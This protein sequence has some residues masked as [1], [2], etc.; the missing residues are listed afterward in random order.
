MRVQFILIMIFSAL[1]FGWP[2]A[3]AN[4]AGPW[5]AQIVDADTGKSLDGVVVLAVWYR[6]YASLGGWAGGGY[7]D[8]EEVVSGA[9]G[10][11]V[12]PSR[13]TWTF[14]PFLTVIQGPE[15]YIFKAGYGQWKFQG[16]EDW[17]YKD[18]LER[19]LHLKQAWERFT[20]KGVI[21][22]LPPLKT[23][24]ERVNF[25]SRPGDVP[26]EHME[27]YLKALDQERIN[28]GLTPGYF[29]QRSEEK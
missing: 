13:W 25:L 26:A 20:G 28:L 8:S 11:F 14:L 22:E 29:R 19:E 16:V 6:R 10:R 3:E 2:S 5:K 1:M 21:L 7:Y 24:E 23:R 18:A 9:D 17:P 15:L 27:R 12:I 4:A